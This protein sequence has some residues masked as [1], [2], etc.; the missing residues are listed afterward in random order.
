MVDL[1]GTC[2]YEMRD[3]DL[4]SSLVYTLQCIASIDRFVVAYYPD[5]G[6]VTFFRRAL[7]GLW[8]RRTMFSLFLH[9]LIQSV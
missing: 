4:E 2:N 5:I 3:V 1:R 9:R 8:F 6:G 7:G